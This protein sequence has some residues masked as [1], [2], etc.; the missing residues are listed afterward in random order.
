M[1][2]SNFLRAS[3]GAILILT[4]CSDSQSK[5]QVR[6]QAP[7]SG[8]G[9]TNLHLFV[10][11]G[12][13]YLKSHVEFNYWGSLIPVFGASAQVNLVLSDK[14]SRQLGTFEIK[15]GRNDIW[16]S[17]P[18]NAPVSAQMRVAGRD[19]GVWT[20]GSIP[21][22]A[23][24]Q[25]DVTLELTQSGSGT[26]TTNPG[27]IAS[28]TSPAPVSQPS[29]PPPAAQPAPASAPAV[30]TSSA[31]PQPQPVTVSIIAT[32]AP[33]STP[34]AVSA[35][36]LAPD[37]AVSPATVPA[38]NAAPIAAPV[39]QAPRP[40]NPEGPHQWW[41]L[42]VTTTPAGALISAYDRN[43]SLYQLAKSPATF[44][45]PILTQQDAL[46]IFWQGRQLT[47]I[48]NLN[49]AIT[50]DFTKLPPEVVGATLVPANR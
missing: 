15:W 21:V 29:P 41:Q 35:P 8:S 48:P 50:I 14:S 43:Q 2:R 34:A 9:M 44:V 45:W 33:A 11:L 24:S 42:S 27:P 16:V 38:P 6:Y 32:P 1:S 20:V 7:A 40:A 18:S 3:F 31:P 28:A 10:N 30:A 25:Q 37:S 19:K 26:I 39:P 36:A 5:S 22:G 46:V 23:L 47:V 4:G 13:E 49:E 12:K 17:A